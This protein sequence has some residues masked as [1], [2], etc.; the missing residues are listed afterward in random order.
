M[1]DSRPPSRIPHPG[2]IG[3]EPQQRAGVSLGVVF[4]DWPKA[5]DKMGRSRES[6]G[7]TASPGSAD[8]RQSPCGSHWNQTAKARNLFWKAPLR[9]LTVAG[10]TSS[11]LSPRFWQRHVPRIN[12][13]GL[14]QLH[15]PFIHVATT[16]PGS[17]IRTPGVQSATPGLEAHS[18]AVSGLSLMRFFG[19]GLCRVLNY[20]HIELHNQTA[21]I[22][23][24]PGPPRAEWKEDFLARWSARETDAGS[25]ETT[26]PLR[27][28]GDL[29]HSWLGRIHRGL[30]RQDSAERSV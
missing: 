10:I 28:P 29:R 18:R 26:L 13:S 27:Q 8:S 23:S 11:P 14:G 16:A 3:H 22:E 30:S 7:I 24:L 5:V 20:T 9:D 25:F 4:R 1:R 15:V 12:I 17:T 2:V 19:K 6:E 21:A